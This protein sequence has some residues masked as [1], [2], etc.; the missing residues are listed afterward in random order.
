MCKCGLS[1]KIIN[2]RHSCEG[3]APYN[4]II[5]AATDRKFFSLR[6]KLKR[7]ISAALMV[8]EQSVFESDLKIQIPKVVAFLFVHSS[9]FMFATA[10]S[11]KVSVVKQVVFKF[12]PIVHMIA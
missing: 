11:I 10:W 1:W 2:A 8:E 6:N 4:R 5:N 12:I 9:E 7:L 3:N